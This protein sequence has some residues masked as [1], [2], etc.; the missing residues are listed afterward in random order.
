MK[1]S[2]HERSIIDSAMQIIRERMTEYA[3]DKEFD[4]PSAVKNYLIMKLHNYE[5]EVFSCLFLNNQH[6]LIADEILFRGTIDGARVYPREV[7]KRAL[8]LNAAA[9]IFV[10]NHP[11]GA[12]VASSA[13]DMIT[14]RLQDAL[15]LV[16]IKTLDHIIVGGI[17]TMSYAEQGKI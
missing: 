15:D 6:K 14:R 4:S 5:H 9:V 12:V 11:S 8:E 17:E 16:D 1:Y 13:D 7:V 2:D 3:V 10:H